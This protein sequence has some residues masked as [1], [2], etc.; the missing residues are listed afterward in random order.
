MD[1]SSFSVLNYFELVTKHFEGTVTRLTNKINDFVRNASFDPDNVYMF[2]F[3]FGGRVV[4]EAG[5]RFGNEYGRKIR[6]IDG[7]FVSFNMLNYSPV[8]VNRTKQFVSQRAGAFDF[9]LRILSSEIQR[10]TF[11]VFTRH[12]VSEFY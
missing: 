9:S 3:S 4:L 2:G 8:N 6:Q 1:F 10:R 11:N 7:N 12:L 5:K